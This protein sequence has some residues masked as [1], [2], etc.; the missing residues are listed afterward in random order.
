[1]ASGESEA[2]RGCSEKQL[3]SSEEVAS[4]SFFFSSELACLLFP[5]ESGRSYWWLRRVD[6]IWSSSTSLIFWMPTSCRRRRELPPKPP[7]E[8]LLPMEA[9]AD[10]LPPRPGLIVGCWRKG[11]LIIVWPS[12]PFCGAV[13]S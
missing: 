6:G 5:L 4:F 13:C 3:E 1:M 9:T 10:L 2:D 8:W 7:K 11:A 12:S